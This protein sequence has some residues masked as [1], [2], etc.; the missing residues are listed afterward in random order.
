MRISKSLS[1]FLRHDATGAKRCGMRRDGFVKLDTLLSLQRFKRFMGDDRKAAVERIKRIV[2][3]NDKKRFTLRAEEDGGELWI[4]ANQGH[5]IPWLE[6][7]MRKVTSA[8]E[9]GACVH[10]TTLEA[11]E[12]FISKEG[13]CRMRR[14]H[15]HMALDLPGKDGV[16]SGARSSS[17]VFVFVD[18]AKLLKAGI[19]LFLSS[20]GV[21]LS[22]GVGERGM[23][24][25]EYFIKV[26]FRG[27][28]GQAGRVEWLGGGGGDGAGG[29]GGRGDGGRGRGGGGGGGG[30]GGCGE[31]GAAGA[32]G[33]G[34]A[35]MAAAAAEA[36][37]TAAAASSS[38]SSDLS[39]DYFVVL[40]FEATC[41]DGGTVPKSKQEI[42]EFPAVLL[43]GKTLEPVDELQ[44]YV[45]PVIV[46]KIT[47]F[48]ESAESPPPPPPHVSLLF[49]PSDRSQSPTYDHLR[50]TIPQRHR[51]HGH[52]AGYDRRSRREL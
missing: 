32:G 37:A 9:C 5:S 12:K 44:V 14:Q 19:S 38:S 23:I 20:N 18:A 31:D 8:E 13:L 48:C 33:T 16:I 29:G 49:P 43:D 6:V 24:S 7:D 34:A 22:P 47:K 41:D 1:Q 17:H 28:K 52:H 3:G 45:K 51:A 40:D 26:M 50:P 4:R 21:V 39:F 2:D 35:G 27:R 10:G 11:W 25:P 36:T 30:C 46:P 42:I 15:V